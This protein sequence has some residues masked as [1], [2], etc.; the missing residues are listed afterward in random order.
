[1]LRL[2]RVGGSLGTSQQRKK[3]LSLVPIWV[4]G[5]VGVS[6][7]GTAGSPQPHVGMVLKDGGKEESCQW[8]EFWAKHSATYLVW[9]EKWPKVR[10]NTGSW[11]KAE[12]GPASRLTF[13]QPCSLSFPPTGF[14]PKGTS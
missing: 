5:Y 6:R 4:S 12:A 10:I 7:E 1:M 3:K 11:A 8:A 9:K 2:C 14:D 13:C